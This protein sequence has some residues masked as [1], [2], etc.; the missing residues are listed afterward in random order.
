MKTYLNTLN[1]R[2]KW[3][4][5]VAGVS[6][7]IY[8]YYLLLYAPLSNQV[9]QK[10]TQLIEKTETLEWMKQVRMQ[11]RSA[12]RKESVDNSQLLTI[13]ASQLK[14]NKTLKFP[15]QLQQ[16]GSGDVQLTFDAVPFQNFIQWLAKINE[17]Y[18]INIKQF[19][20]EKTPTPGVT[21]LMIILSAS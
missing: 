11:K 14:N 17:V 6:L 10:S 8:G 18:S 19:D 3:M 16:T 9:N 20:V 1:D 12:K 7:F 4:V 2:E 13:L 5:I 21:R 15:Y